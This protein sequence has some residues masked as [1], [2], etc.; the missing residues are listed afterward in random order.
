VDK[1]KVKPAVKPLAEKALHHFAIAPKL[2][3][4]REAYQKNLHS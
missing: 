4:F 1:G 3:R 2:A